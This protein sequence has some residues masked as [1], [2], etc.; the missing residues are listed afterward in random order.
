[1]K[2][3]EYF[4]KYETK[5]ISGGTDALYQLFME[6][7]EESKVLIKTRHCRSNSAVV[8]VIKELNGKWNAIS[9]LFEK[10]YNGLS[11]LKKDGFKNFWLREVPEMAPYFR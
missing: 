11:P 9:N 3:K 8:A 2:A 6:I 4:T 10:K 7:N 5:I 1:L